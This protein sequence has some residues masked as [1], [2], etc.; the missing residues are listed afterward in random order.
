M[1]DISILPTVNASL[2]LISFV[3]I[4]SGYVMIKRGDVQKHK[5]CMISAFC[6]SVLFLISYLTYAFLGEE[7]RFSGTGWIRPVY[8]TILITHVVLAATVPVLATWTLVLGLQGRFDKHRKLA[9]ITFPIWA[10]VS[11]TGVIV[12]L[13]LFRL[14]GPVTAPVG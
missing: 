11:T 4:M 7:K 10:Y 1:L 6:V 9:R 13:L 12:Y 3:L 5:A 14:F 2:N 8:F